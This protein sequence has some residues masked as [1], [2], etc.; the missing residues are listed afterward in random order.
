MGVASD[1][2]A[3]GHDADGSNAALI[4]Q[5]IPGMEF[6]DGVY[7]MRVHEIHDSLL[8]YAKRWYKIVDS[9]GRTVRVNALEI[10][11]YRDVETVHRMIQARDA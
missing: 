2:N 9:A 10:T 7:I 5:I 6:I 11:V 3:A 8:I 4:R 1:T